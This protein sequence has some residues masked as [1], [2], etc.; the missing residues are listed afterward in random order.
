MRKIVFML[1]FLFLGLQV[2]AQSTIKGVV[3]DNNGDPVPGAN[4]WVKGF[5]NVGT[6]TD[7]S[8]NYSISA[9]AEATTIV[10]SFMG[11]KTKEV[12]IGGQT[13]INVSL[14]SEDQTID[15]VVVTALGIK[16]SKKALGYA[17]QE[18][19]SEEMQQSGK[20][21]MVS[22]LQGKVA[23]VNI[24]SAGGAG[25]STRIVIRGA[26]S[27]DPNA[28]NQ[29]L[30][31]IDGVPISNQT[32]SGSIAP[33]AG[34]NAGSASE[35]FGFSNRAMDINP[36][37]IESI[38][39]LKGASATALYGA[40]AAN[41]AIIITTKKGKN[42][43]TTINF[44][45]KV[46]I[47]KV[48]RFPEMQKTW[49]MGTLSA[50]DLD[51]PPVSV[52]PTSNLGT[53]YEFGYRRADTGEP[54]YDNM[55][56]FFETGVTYN[57]NLA[58]SSGSEKGSYYFSVSDLR[59]TGIVPNTTWGR[60]S[61]KLNA[62]KKV[63]DR[64]STSASLTYT[65]TG[66]DRGNHGD[67]SYM[68]SMLYMSNSMDMSNYKDESGA[69]I[70]HP[71]IDNPYY[72]L[73]KVKYTDDVNR[74]T[75]YFDFDFKI[76]DHINLKYRLGNDMYSD[77][78]TYIVPW[79]EVPGEQ[80]LDVSTQVH[81]FMVEERINFNELNSDIMIN[82]DY[83]LTQDLKLNVL[84]GQNVMMQDYDR[85]NTRGEGWA[86]PGFYDIS[87]TA[88]KFSSNSAYRKR[89]VG[90]Y[91]DVRL[92][93]KDYLFLDI[94]GR[95][96]ISS[97][98]PKNARSYFYPSVNLGF[99]FTDAFG[100]SSDKFN[101]GK[102]RASWAKVAK[103][104][105]PN[106]LDKY[107]TAYTHG[108]NTA[109]TKDNSLGNTAL[110]PEMTTS[111]EFGLDMRF[112]NN[113][114]GVD[115][116]WY[117]ANTVDMLFPIPVAYSTG[118][119]S[120]LDN[121]GELENKGIEFLLTG[122]PVRTSGFSWDI[123]LNFSK[124]KTK[125]VKLS[126]DLE[127]IVSSSG[128]S[129]VHTKLVEGGYY[130]DMYGYTYVNDTAADGTISPI[131]GADGR[132][133]NDWDNEVYIGNV[134]PDWSM[135]IT[136]TLKYKGI[137]LSFLIDIKQ[138]QVV[139]ND[140]VRMLI[141]QGKHISTEYR[142]LLS[143]GGMVL[144]GVMDDGTGNYVKNTNVLQNYRYFYR[145][146]QQYNVYDIVDDASWVRLRS[147]SLGYSL[148][149]SILG[150]GKFL[151]GLTA[152]FTGTNLF[153]NTPYRGFDPE[154]SRNGAASNA[155]GYAGYSTPNTSTYSFSLNFTF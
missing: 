134:N 5:S 58:I 52:D 12:A 11:M 49:G 153:I 15:D 95:N 25:A 70:T 115:F 62:T 93:F 61:V 120:I 18:V 85:L 6:I 149:K 16:R 107:Y 92:D 27:L 4:V 99:V 68:S 50:A 123:A 145:F 97:T 84:L 59:Q 41:G 98:L 14:E 73:E 117:K 36:D 150:E 29:P 138:G 125:V 96:D 104:A 67:K 82:F 64:F 112:F 51:D 46:T 32:V 147:L 63:S 103:D 31:V 132:P 139:L 86:S 33:S 119:S 116:S 10:F 37:D 122:T 54:Y 74:I 105:P 135:G 108:S 39:V 28:D 146:R 47:D 142:P 102:I 71:W 77:S 130:G 44:N 89:I 143:E 111:L 34:S 79:A 60:K 76:T 90:F 151:K 57:N 141:R 55:K 40:R 17:V 109:L 53:F 155:Q 19:S 114:L 91:G 7:M 66:G 69:M 45:S 81:G 30:F 21:D 72:L 42:G 133:T 88:F 126:N 106:R 48:T 100:I 129:G 137:I 20:A 113:R 140:H 80:P 83:D 148:P 121:L 1:A 128:S 13:T 78:R 65:N 24:T 75:G 38:S 35:Q 3:T 2:F 118:Y 101:Y 9:P 136:N 124:N 152:T 56:N 144:D 154:I 131:I 26:N 94:T 8:G 43:V 110:K 23:G 22:A 127:E 87:N